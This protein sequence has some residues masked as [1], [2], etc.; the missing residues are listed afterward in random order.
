VVHFPARN[1]VVS[2]YARHTACQEV[3][4]MISQ[5]SL[6]D[7]LKRMASWV[8][9]VGPRKSKDFKNIEIKKNLPEAWK[10]DRS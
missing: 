8:A 2:A 10:S 6:T 1:E 5:T 7:G 4:G 3:F 9:S